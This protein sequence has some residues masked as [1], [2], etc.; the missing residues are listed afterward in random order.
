MKDTQRA[1]S[2]LRFLRVAWKLWVMA[3]GFAAGIFF[4]ALSLTNGS[5]AVGILVLIIL[6]LA[7]GCLVRALARENLVAVLFVILVVGECALL[8]Q[9]PAP[10]SRLWPVLI[11]ANAIGVMMG[12]LMRL[13]LLESNRRVLRDVWVING[14]EY[15]QTESA[16][17]TS[18]AILSVWD[19]AK[20]GRFF[21]ERNEGLFE[22]VGNPATGFLVHCAANFQEESYW[23][24]LGLIDGKEATEIRIPSGPAFAPSGVVVDLEAAKAALLGF[25]HFRGPDPELSWTSGDAVLDLRLG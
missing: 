6:G 16:R 1:S 5:H 10:W 9:S 25:F 18:L 12:N 21:I 13:G 23:R 17:A 2:L 24:L 7:G 11:P 3:L 4:S 19:S 8:S 22:A 20:S 15:P 14:V